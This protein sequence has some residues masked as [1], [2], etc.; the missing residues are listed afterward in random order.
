MR[1]P[2]A[3]L[4]L[5]AALSS[6]SPAAARWLIDTDAARIAELAFEKY[7]G[8]QHMEI[9]A[10]AALTLPGTKRYVL[11][12]TQ[13]AASEMTDA[14]AFLI[15]DRISGGVWLAGSDHCIGIAAP[16]LNT[17]R[18]SLSLE[19]GPT[20]RDDPPENYCRLEGLDG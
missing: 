16:E 7:C 15:V 12:Q 5:A 13:F 18:V 19:H 1:P 2:L 10:D 6:A 14:W 11:F 17:L 3:A 20:E 9:T 4:A 8:A